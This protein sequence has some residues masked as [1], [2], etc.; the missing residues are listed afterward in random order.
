MKENFV[1][2]VLAQE[3]FFLTGFGN[4]NRKHLSAICSYNSSQTTQ[5]DHAV[6]QKN[7]KKTAVQRE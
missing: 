7:N 6:L 3:Y 1:V 5:A 4:L 2:F